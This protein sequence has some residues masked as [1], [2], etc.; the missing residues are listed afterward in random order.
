MNIRV[1]MNMLDEYT[2][3][4]LQWNYFTLFYIMCEQFRF[5]VELI[6]I[7]RWCILALVSIHQIGR[8]WLVNMFLHGFAAIRLFHVDVYLCAMCHCVRVYSVFYLCRS[9][10]LSIFLT[11]TSHY[12]QYFLSVVV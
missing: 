9:V 5:L 6:F 7:F 8:S 12:Q 10:Q 1:F 4:A 11:L 2:N 3:V